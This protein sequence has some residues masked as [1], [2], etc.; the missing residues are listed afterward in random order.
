AGDAGQQ[1]PR[2]PPL[3]AR[4]SVAGDA[5]AE[6]TGARDVAGVEARDGRLHGRAQFV[7]DYEANLYIVA[8]RARGLHLV[9]ADA[10]GLTRT[11]FRTIDVTRPTGE[12]V[13]D[14]VAAE[15]L[16]AGDGPAAVRAMIDAGRLMLAADTLGAT[17]DM[18]D[19]AVA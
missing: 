8:D 11:D 12:L 13:F 3:P 9:A 5:L 6:S 10:P 2:L 1:A 18:L 4:A 16:K 14:G 7:V 19:Q 15:P 17:Q